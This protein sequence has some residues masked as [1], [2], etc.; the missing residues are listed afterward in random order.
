MRIIRYIRKRL[1]CG[2]EDCIE[3]DSNGGRNK[4][5]SVEEHLNQIRSNLKDELNHI[6]KS[7]TLK[8]QLAIAVNF[9]S[10]KDIDE[11]DVIHAKTDNKE[12]K[13]NGKAD[14]VIQK[15]FK[16]LLNRYQNYLETSTRGSDF[17]FDCIHLYLYK[18]H[19]IY[20]NRGEPYIHFPNWIK[21]KYKSYNKENKYFLICCNSC[22][23][24]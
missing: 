11:E 6:K 5:L 14:K 22:I 16:T 19:K 15:L 9:I 1:E 8:I 3:Y 24:S 23:K 4:T 2:K 10:S 18:C 17:I 13:M 12:I 21:N 7:D 20:P